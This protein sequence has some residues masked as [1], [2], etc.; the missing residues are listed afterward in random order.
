M[1][2]KLKLLT[3]NRLSLNITY[4]KAKEILATKNIKSK[5]DYYKLC[6]IDLRFSKEPD[7]IFKGYFKDWID[8][9]SINRDYYD[10]GTCKIK[11]SEYLIKYPELKEYFIELTII[12]EKLCEIDNNF[13]PSDLWIDYYNIK[14]LSEL[15][16]IQIYKKKN[17]I[18]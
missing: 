16:I 15:I 12:S 13:P 1:T 17:I 11:I 14:D 7:I 10:F 3:I 4:E 2:K 18:I 8:Y 9:L 6:D 5:K